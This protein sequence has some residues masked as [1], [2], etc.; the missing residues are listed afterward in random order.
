MREARGTRGR[1]SDALALANKARYY[2]AVSWWSNRLARQGPMDVWDIS[3]DSVT[4]LWPSCGTLT[5]SSGRRPASGP[6][7]PQ[8]RAGL[9]NR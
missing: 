4:N 3:T 6:G 9:G 2:E 8:L 1:S 7:V 5:Q